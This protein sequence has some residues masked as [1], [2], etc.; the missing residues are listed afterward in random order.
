MR[1]SS[2]GDGGAGIG[3]PAQA[4]GVSPRNATGLVDTLER[5]GLARR[6]APRQP[7]A[8]AIR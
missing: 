3:E 4:A 7:K 1:L 6:T 2:A 5:D 8:A